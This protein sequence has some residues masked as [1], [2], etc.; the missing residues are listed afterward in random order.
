MRKDFSVEKMP[1][2]VLT[3]TK[4]LREGLH[5]TREKFTLTRKIIAY[6]TTQSWEK[7]PHCAFTYEPDATRL[8]E[9]YKSL[10]KNREGDGVLTLNSLMI[11]I[12]VEALKA[13]PKLNAYVEYN[14][15]NSRGEID[16]IQEINVSMPMKLSN[17]STVTVNLRGLEK[18]DL[19]SIGELVN[20]TRRRAENTNFVELYYRVAVKELT[21]D[22]SKLKVASFVRKIFAG[23]IG[24]DKVNPLK[25]DEKK[26]YYAI[27]ES[28]RLAIK[29]VRQG[30][31][32]ITNIGSLIKGVNGMMSLIEIVP[33]QII[34]F[35]I[36]PV[37]EK[38]GAAQD[39]IPGSPIEMRK[40]LP[41]CM[42]FDHRACDFDALVPLLEKLEEIFRHPEIIHYM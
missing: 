6:K 8:L 5:Y 37:I 9:E 23:R 25:G 11:R 33:P 18:M 20:D 31:V 40:F 35:G 41:I 16:T 1:D 10:K 28:D 7:V 36:S 32:V 3:G 22:L 27:P 12:L 24:A 42:V 13:A 19:A 38:P 29:D 4:G 39:S 26:R 2:E 17:G 15:K 14:K 21:E 30:T 34:A